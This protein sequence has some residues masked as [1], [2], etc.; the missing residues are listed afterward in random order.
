MHALSTTLGCVVLCA[1]LAACAT[2][3]ADTVKDGSYTLLPTQSATLAT[4]VTLRYDSVDDSRCPA[5][6]QCVAAGRLVYHVTLAA[7]GRNEAFDL[8]EAAPQFNSAALKGV[9]VVLANPTVPP[10]RAASAAPAP[11]PVVLNVF[12][13]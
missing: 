11:L 10:V 3:A 13:Q 5:G 1:S 12:H 7:A 8:S 4:G 9:R 6:V 2:G